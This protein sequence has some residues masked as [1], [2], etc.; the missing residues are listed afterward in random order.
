MNRVLRRPMFRIGGSTEGITSGLAPR[1]GY[2]TNEDNLVKKND[3]SKMK[4]SALGD[5]DIGQLRELSKS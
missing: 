5:M 4:L 1:Q 3:F 2:A